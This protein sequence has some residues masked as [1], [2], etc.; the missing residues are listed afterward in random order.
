MRERGRDDLLS[1]ELP[2]LALFHAIPMFPGRGVGPSGTYCNSTEIVC[3]KDGVPPG[4]AAAERVEHALAVQSIL[5][6][7]SKNFESGYASLGAGEMDGVLRLCDPERV[8]EKH[9]SPLTLEDIDRVRALIADPGRAVLIGNVVAET[10]LQRL[11]W[12]A[13]DDI[14]HCE[15]QVQTPR[16]ETQIR[17]IPVYFGFPFFR[18]DVMSTSRCEE[19]LADA[20]VGSSRA[21][22]ADPVDRWDG[23]L[24]PAE[25]AMLWG[26]GVP[27]AANLVAV[28][29]GASSVC[30]RLPKCGEG[31]AQFEV[32]RSIKL[33]ADSWPRLR[34]DTSMEIELSIGSPSS[35]V[36]V[37]DLLVKGEAR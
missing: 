36:V 12:E 17:R 1:D 34:I 29:A 26:K 33:G 11:C 37:R 20:Q 23:T 8:I 14:L 7:I 19:A 5:T 28:V 24:R 18:N 3:A 22:A 27:L 35:L 4:G 21:R 16:G 31:G 13:G 30:F 32:V 2:E 25:I 15:I 6:R 10:A 9:L